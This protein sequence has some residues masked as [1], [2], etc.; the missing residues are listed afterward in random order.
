V[1]NIFDA[2]RRGLEEEY[3]HRKDKESLERLREHIREEAHKHK[4]E[5][6]TMD[7]PRCTGR[8]HVETYNDVQVDRCDTCGGVWIDAGELAEILSQNNVATQ[9]F[10]ALWPGRAN[11]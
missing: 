5:P 4:G 9:W 11:E 2:R 8:L 3:I 10:H 1:S 7:C 6:S